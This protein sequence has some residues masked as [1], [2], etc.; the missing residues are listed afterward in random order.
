MKNLISILILIL[1]ISGLIGCTEKHKEVPTSFE[2]NFEDGIKGWHALGSTSISQDKT[3]YH[4]GKASLKIEGVGQIKLYSFAQSGKMIL[5][6]GKTYRLTGWML[7]DSISEQSSFLKCE[8][9]QDDKWIENKDTNWYDLKRRG[10]WQKLSA[11]FVALK[12]K[13][14]TADITVEKRPM[15]KDV[16]ATIYIDS[17]ALELIK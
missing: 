1:G 10:Q 15:E 2:Y 12:G 11:E 8:L 17:I 6:P 9:Y 4:D 3:Q 16:R 7:I 13:N 14:A 5:S